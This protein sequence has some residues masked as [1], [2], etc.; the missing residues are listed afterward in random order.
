MSGGNGAII[1]ALNSRHGVALLDRVTAAGQTEV[2]INMQRRDTQRKR[3]LFLALVLIG[4]DS[5][6]KAHDESLPNHIHYFLSLLV[7]K[8]TLRS[9]SCAA[10]FV[11]MCALLVMSQPLMSFL[12]NSKQTNEHFL[13]PFHWL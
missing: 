10:A 3:E 2:R 8:R 6:L 4:H 5:S 11:H 9:S 12:C 7:R 13:F 1:Q